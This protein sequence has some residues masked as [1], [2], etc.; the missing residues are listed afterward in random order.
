MKTGASFT[1]DVTK[2]LYQPLQNGVYLFSGAPAVAPTPF[3]FRQSFALVPE[4]ALMFP[5]AYVIA[6]FVQDDWRVRNNLTLNLGLRYDVEIIKDIPDWPAD[7]DKNNLDPRVGFAWDPK[8]DQK[9]SDPGRLRPLH[10][11]ARHL[12]HRQRRRRRPQRPGDRIARR[13][14]T[15]CSR[16]SRMRCR[17][18][19][20]VRFCRRATSRRS[21]RISRTSM[22]GPAAWA[23]SISSGPGR[24]SRSTPTSIAASSRVSS[25]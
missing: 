17:P 3:Q 20:R 9:W 15:R 18:S 23:S 16:R 2:Q 1:Y 6:G 24:P 4:A 12:H 13:R 19:R 10:A 21:R 11:A 8:G 7:T 22:P 25:T 14:A 5:K